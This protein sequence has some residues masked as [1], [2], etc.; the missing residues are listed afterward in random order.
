MKPAGGFRAGR[1]AG[2][3]LDDDDSVRAELRRGQFRALSAL[4]KLADRITAKRRIAKTQK[5][6]APWIAIGSGKRI[7]RPGRHGKGP[8]NRA[9]ARI[10]QTE[11]AAAIA[12]RPYF[13]KQT[14]HSPS[15]AESISRV[16]WIQDG[17]K[18]GAISARPG[19]T[20]P[21]H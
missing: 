20:G 18:D 21:R 5:R 13:D 17:G 12:I 15:P 9:A 7:T 14:V 1:I 10:D 4:R 16:H 2:D 3:G 6:I 8:A 19:K 11:T